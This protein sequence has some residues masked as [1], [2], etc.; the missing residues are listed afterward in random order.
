MA[1][2]TC[3]CGRLLSTVMA[4]NDVELWVYTDDE[5]YAILS[6]EEIEAWKVPF[7][8][9]E[10]WKCPRCERIYVFQKDSNHL[11]RVYK[12]GDA[13]NGRN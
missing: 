9:L 10:V 13:G 8:N 3:K 1:K 5:W 2:F 12:P 4:P 7:P 6:N 11:A